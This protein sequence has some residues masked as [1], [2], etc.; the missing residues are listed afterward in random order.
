MSIINETIIACAFGL[1]GIFGL[2]LSDL[3]LRRARFLSAQA[4]RTL[5]AARDLHLKVARY[6]AVSNSASQG[7]L[8]V[9]AAMVDAAGG[10]ITIEPSHFAKAINCRVEWS[11]A[12]DG[13]SL[14]VRTRHQPA[15]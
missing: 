6:A 12:D 1:V 11:N 3:R 10:E 9:V 5:S 13:Q 15:N 4:D 7:T 14:I 8:G 2:A